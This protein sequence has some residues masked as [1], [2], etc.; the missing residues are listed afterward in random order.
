MPTRKTE[1]ATLLQPLYQKTGGIVGA[2]GVNTYFFPSVGFI[3]NKGSYRLGIVKETSLHP[4][5]CVAPYTLAGKS[6]F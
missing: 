1:K 2:A 5:Q 4:K 6:G 3:P